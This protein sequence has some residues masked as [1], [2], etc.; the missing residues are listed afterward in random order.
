M[1]TFIDDD[2]GYLGSKPSAVHGEKPPFIAE[3]LP[4]MRKTRR[5]WR[6]RPSDFMIVLKC[7][8]A[9]SL[10]RPALIGKHM[11]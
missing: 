8:A 5:S 3:K 11:T 7:P 9:T 1:R 10:G 4:F 2:A 6:V